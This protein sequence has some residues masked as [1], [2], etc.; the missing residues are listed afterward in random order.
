MASD[1]GVS[2]AH[3]WAIEQGWAWALRRGGTAHLIRDG[4]TRCGRDATGMVTIERR[5][6]YGCWACNDLV[7]L[8]YDKAR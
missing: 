5:G 7:R 6:W 3:R 4:K 8:D 2:E 1:R